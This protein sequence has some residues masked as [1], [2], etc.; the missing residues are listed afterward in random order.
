[1]S[2]GMGRYHQDLKIAAPYYPMI[3]IQ[4]VNHLELNKLLYKNQNGF[5][6]S[7]STECNLTYVTKYILN[8]LND[9]IFVLA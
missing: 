8:T 2:L 9:K 5:K 7:K 3:S 1:M 4:L 6:R